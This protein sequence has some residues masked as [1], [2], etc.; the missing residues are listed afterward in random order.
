MTMIQPN[1]MNMTIFVTYSPITEKVVS[2]ILLVI[3]QG[4]GMITR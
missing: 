1:S 3:L 2:I 4:W